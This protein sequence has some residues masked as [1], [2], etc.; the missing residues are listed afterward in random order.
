MERRKT[1][2]SKV[3]V[4][5]TGIHFLL[6]RRRVSFIINVINRR[7]AFRPGRCSTFKCRRFFSFFASFP[8]QRLRP[9]GD[10]RA[11]LRS[12]RSLA[13]LLARL[14]VLTSLAHASPPVQNGLAGVLFETFV[15]TKLDCRAERESF[16]VRAAR[17]ATRVS[18]PSAGNIY[19]SVPVDASGV[20]ASLRLE[21]TVARRPAESVQPENS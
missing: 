8:Y 11:P 9:R 4:R 5:E 3:P 16:P 18:S 14:L 15:L 21:P 6:K 19:L 1:E 2:L 20:Q 17:F 10:P 7:R 13:R 12:V